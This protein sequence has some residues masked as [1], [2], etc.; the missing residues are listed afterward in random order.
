MNVIKWS[1][2]SEEQKFATL[3]ITSVDSFPPYTCQKKMAL[4]SSLIF[5]AHLFYFGDTACWE[6][7]TVHLGVVTINQVKTRSCEVLDLSQRQR[8]RW[9][10]ALLTR[11]LLALLSH[12]LSAPLVS[13]VYLSQTHTHHTFGLKGSL[14]AR[15]SGCELCCHTSSSSS[16]L[17][18]AV[19]SKHPAARFLSFVRFPTSQEAEWPVGGWHRG[20]WEWANDGDWEQV[21]GRERGRRRQR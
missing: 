18:I 21:R 20:M 12:S 19:C 1:K 14:W 2:E 7:L 4:R 5:F 10:T 16:E 6:D 8:R 9:L 13:T 3:C 17:R 15:A 11:S